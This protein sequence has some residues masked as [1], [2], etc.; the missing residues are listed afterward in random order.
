MQLRNHSHMP[1]PDTHCS[2]SG[3]C[4]A[5][6]VSSEGMGVKRVMP[7][8]AGLIISSGS[9]QQ[10]RGRG[11]AGHGKQAAVSKRI[12]QGGMRRST[13]IGVSR[14][15]HSVE[16]D[17][18]LHCVGTAT[19]AWARCGIELRGALRLR[20]GGSYEDILILFLKLWDFWRGRFARKQHITLRI[21]S[22]LDGPDWPATGRSVTG[23]GSDAE[24]D[25]GGRE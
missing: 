25:T 4:V 22:A 9:I 2:I 19:W 1:E 18:A 12:R 20:R 10:D 5:Y 11:S 3:L 24:Q 17:N 21:Q 16:S 8:D 6:R 23:M 7:G 14:F 13:E 15:R